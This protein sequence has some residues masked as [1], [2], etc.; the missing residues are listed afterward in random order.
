MGNIK[1]Q[2]FAAAGLLVLMSISGYVLAAQQSSLHEQALLIAKDRNASAA[3]KVLKLSELAATDDAHHSGLADNVNALRD[4]LKMLDVVL[5]HDFIFKTDDVDLHL[6][7]ARMAFDELERMGGVDS[8]MRDVIARNQAAAWNI[9]DV[10]LLLPDRPGKGADLL[11]DKLIFDN[12]TTGTPAYVRLDGG[13]GIVTSADLSRGPRIIVVAG[14][15][16]SDRAAMAINDNPAL[17]R[18]FKDARALWVTPA[19]NS[20][21]LGAIRA[22]NARMP[23]QQIVISY[24]NNEWPALDFSVIPS[25]YVFHDGEVVADLQGWPVD[26][27]V[28][29]ELL[30][31][32]TRIGKNRE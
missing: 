23:D 6:A 14:C 32:L 4:R 28:P 8:E 1:I 30:Q 16:I 11:P 21:D 25:F 3:T 20:A 19:S 12:Y 13:A 10:S 7:Q 27:S 15:H 31:A 29:E 2:F 17:K 5:A 9:E 26:G 18:A 22:W 24:R